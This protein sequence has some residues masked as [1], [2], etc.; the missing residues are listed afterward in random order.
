MS[1]DIKLLLEHAAHTTRPLPG[2]DDAWKR[3]RE[4]RRRRAAA[5]ATSALA[6]VVVVALLAGPVLE[7]EVRT[8]P[9]PPMGQDRSELPVLSGS[10]RRLPE[11]P[12]DGARYDIASVWTGTE[13]LYWGGRQQGVDGGAD[14]FDGAAYNPARDKW[15]EIS[16]PRTRPLEARTTVWTGREMILWGGEEGDGSHERPDDGVAYDPDSDTWRKLSRSPN[17]SLAG[18]SAVWTGSEMIVW[19]GVGMGDEGAAYLPSEDSWRELPPPPVRGRERHAAVWTGEEMIVWGGNRAGNTGAGYDPATD[20]WRK[21][22]PSP[23]KG[24]DLP[25]VV[26]SGSE[27]IVWGGMTDKASSTKGAAY[28]PLSDSWRVI[29]DAPMSSWLQNAI[30]TGKYMIVQAG[31]S[32]RL[33]A[34]SP[35][36]DEWAMLPDP[37]K[38][39]G[40]VALLTWTGDELVVW[41]GFSPRNPERSSG[42][43]F[44][45]D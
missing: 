3:S 22:P 29:A 6:S 23:L 13:I 2:F 25:Y 27:M 9:H 43:A 28:N 15:R 41:G 21:L 4:L 20:T 24:A 16:P 37:P 8:A 19:G 11:A 44:T 32:D 42:A 34:Y 45:F 7:T 38:G 17:W 40:M 36:D 35:E 10:W 14:F 39:T 5:V 26:W 12:I 33:M 1:S 31:M 18:H 30:W